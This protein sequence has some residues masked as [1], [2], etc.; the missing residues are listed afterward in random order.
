MAEETNTWSGELTKA[1]K[2]GGGRVNEGGSKLQSL[3]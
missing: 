2:E 3:T 1:T